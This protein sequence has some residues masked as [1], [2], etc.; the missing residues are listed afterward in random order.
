MCVIRN[1]ISTFSWNAWLIL[2]GSAGKVG[3]WK[4]HFTVA[5]NEEFEEDYKKKM[6][7]HT[8]QFRTEV[9]AGLNRRCICYVRNKKGMCRK[10]SQWFINQ[11][12]SNKQNMGWTLIMST[13]LALYPLF[14]RFT[15]MKCVIQKVFYSC[16]YC[17]YAIKLLIHIVCFV[18]FS[19][20]HDKIV[21]LIIDVD[22][23]HYQLSDVL[24]AVRWLTCCLGHF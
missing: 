24:C 10:I 1:K 9:W 8:L 23:C 6:K 13:L 17:I 11:K 2:C 3:D 5:Q 12:S 21:R 22:S 15:R 16:Q 20:R 18:V 4:N 19:V 7:D 14:W